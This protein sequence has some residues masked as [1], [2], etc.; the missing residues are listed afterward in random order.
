MQHGIGRQE[1]VD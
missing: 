1:N